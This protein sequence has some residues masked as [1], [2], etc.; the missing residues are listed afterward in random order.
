MSITQIDIDTCVTV[1]GAP[2]SA[3]ASSWFW[4][5]RDPSSD[6]VLVVSLTTGVDLGDG[7]TTIVSAQTPQ[8]YVELHDVTGLLYIEPDE[9]MFIAKRD[10]RFSS[11]VVGRTATCSQFANIRSSLLRS[12]FSELNPAALM[13]ALQMSLAENMI[14]TM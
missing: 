2:Q 1:L 14:D 5:L 13:A 8:G 7:P 9:V 10:E 12:D 6:R 3:D 4:S 11:L